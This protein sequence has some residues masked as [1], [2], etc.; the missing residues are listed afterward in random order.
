MIRDDTAAIVSVLVLIMVFFI[1]ICLIIVSAPAQPYRAIG[2]EPLREA[3]IAAGVTICNVTDTHW[4]VP[5]AT[6]GKTYIISDNCAARTPE[7]TIVIQV[8]G[9]DS[10]ESRDAAVAT[11]YSQ[12]INHAGPV[13]KLFVY[14]Q[15]VAYIQAEPNSEL[16]KK[17]ADELRKEGYL[18]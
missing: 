14:G 8:Q 15:Y 5:G 3:A 7:N 12:T 17:I 9:F 13:G 11:H 16:V 10:V 6:G 18:S 2:V 1:P 4:N